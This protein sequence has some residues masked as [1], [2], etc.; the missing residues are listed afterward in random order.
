MSLSRRAIVLGS[1]IG[2]SACIDWDP[3][4]A[5]YCADGTKNCDFRLSANTSELDFK[6]VLVG[7]ERQLQWTIRNGSTFPVTWQGQE[8]LGDTDEFVLQD[9]PMAK[10]GNSLESEKECGFTITF[11]PNSVG[12]KSAQ[13]G[14]IYAGNRKMVLSVTG[15]GAVLMTL[16]RVPSDG[17]G[18]LRVDGVEVC[19][20]QCTR[21]E[22][23]VYKIPT[24]VEAKSEWGS[25]FGG[26]NGELCSGHH[27]FCSWT[28]GMPLR[29]SAKFNALPN[30]LVFVSSKAYPTNLGSLTAY[31]AECNN[32]AAE[33][34][35]NNTSKD[36]FVAWM[37]DSKTDVRDRMGLAVRGFIRLDGAPFIDRLE[38]GAVYNTLSIDENGKEVGPTDVITGAWHDG[39]AQPSPDL[40][41]GT[42]ADWTS[43]LG[44]DL[45]VGNTWAGP[46]N[47][48]YD[49]PVRCTEVVG[50]IYCFMKT[51]SQPL[52]MS[53]K[54]GKMAY[55]SGQLFKSGDGDP[56]GVCAATKPAGVAGEVKALISTTETAA[57]QWIKPDEL[58]V[59]PDGQVVGTGQ[60]IIEGRLSSGIWLDALGVYNT[61]YVWTGSSKISEKGTLASTCNNW[62]NDTGM[63]VAGASARIWD[64]L[65]WGWHTPTAKCGDAN[66]LYCVE[67]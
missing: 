67:Q 58:Y 5:Q 4:V 18:V 39:T 47:W 51:Y 41:L 25:Y 15:G 54:Q 13:F 66:F 50:R 34:G 60:A 63:G 21:V 11:R 49:R 26:W 7:E 43:S 61:W 1:F 55:L 6:A 20:K 64:W 56:D 48:S 42:C 3:A 40:F 62:Q 32:L 59:R 33:A 52:V 10:C 45:L 8:A 2:L 22:V 53:K 23:P 65:W 28:E 16:E 29:A 14:L 27:R 44:E 35:L 12:I 24:V 36:A 19:G 37:A 57:A 46:L 31:D 9:G 17:A 30:N 38:A